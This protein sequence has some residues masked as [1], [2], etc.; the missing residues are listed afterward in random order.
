MAV[1]AR[2][3]RVVAG[4]ILV[5]GIVRPAP[6]DPRPAARRMD[7]ANIVI[8]CGAMG[9]LAVW[10]AAAVQVPGERH[11]LRDR[12]APARR[13]VIQEHFALVPA[14]N[15]FVLRPA[16]TRCRSTSAITP[17]ITTS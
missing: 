11:D 8:Q 17:N 1:R 16:S 15:L 13:A 4:T 12:S 6:V 2:R 7:V 3:K 10:A 5:Q 9:L 14:R